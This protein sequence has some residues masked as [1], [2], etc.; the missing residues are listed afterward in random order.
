M[1]IILEFD[2]QEEANEAING[3]RFKRALQDYDNY[4][5]QQI[6]YNDKLGEEELLTLQCV[7]AE[8]YDI[9]KAD[10]IELYD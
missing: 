9:L 6:K 2:N 7:R 3:Y 1:K 4:L 5:R 10:N 8:L